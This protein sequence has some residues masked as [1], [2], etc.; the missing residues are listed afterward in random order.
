MNKQLLEAYQQTTY[1]ILDP[2]FNIRV[3]ELHPSLDQYLE[4]SEHSTWAFITAWNPKSQ[5]LT[6]SENRDRNRSL[7]AQ[8]KSQEFS[9]YKA[10]G[11]PDKGD[12]IPEDS[13]FI[14]GISRKQAIKLGEK[15]YQNAIVFGEIGKSAEL[16]VLS[17]GLE[18]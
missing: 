4:K 10:L 15:F 5:E 2:E 9:A 11:V 17:S 1:R 18:L 16:L 7:V 8:L 13:I 6:I 3:G 12:W 14:P